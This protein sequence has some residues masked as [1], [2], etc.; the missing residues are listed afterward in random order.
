[1]CL[2]LAS[3]SNTSGASSAEGSAPAGKQVVDDECVLEFS[4][5]AKGSKSELALLVQIDAVFDKELGCRE[6][7]SYAD[8]MKCIVQKSVRVVD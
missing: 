5:D 1:M 3:R 2:A 7:S 8:T 6:V 4:S